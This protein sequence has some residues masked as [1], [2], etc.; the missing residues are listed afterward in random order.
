MCYVLVT[1]LIRG[2]HP[3]PSESKTS[4]SAATAVQVWWLQALG[5]GF[6]LWAGSDVLPW[7]MQ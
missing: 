5:I 3:Q 7:H 4:Q 1:S 2:E 6:W